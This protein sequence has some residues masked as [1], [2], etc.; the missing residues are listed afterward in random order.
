MSKFEFYELFIENIYIG[1]LILFLCI[2]VTLT[3][4]RKHIYSIFD[5][6]FFFMLLAASGYS[7]VFFLY[8]FNMIS[9]Y[10]F[11]SF[12]S[13]Q[14]AFFFGWKL[15]KPITLNQVIELDFK[16][17]A[18]ADVL[19][20][21]SFIVFL[22]SQILVYYIKGI[23]LFATSRLET[24][25]DGGGFGF[26]NR[27][28][29]VTSIVSLCICVFRLIY[30]NR[31]GFWIFFDFFVL[32][33]FVLTQVFSGSK[34]GL[35]IIIFVAYLTMLFSQKFNFIRFKEKVA[36]RYFIVIVCI[37]IPVAFIT[38][39]IQNILIYDSVDFG[40]IFSGFLMRFLNTGDIYYMAWPYDFLSHI[41]TP[42]DPILALFK[43]IL[44]A[45]R[46]FNKD[47]LPIHIGLKIFNEMY[48]NEALSGPNAR[49]N[50][51]GLF[52]FGPV[53]SIVY[54][55]ILG[56]IVGFIRNFLFFKVRNDIVGLTV[57]V[58]CAY[59]S[60]FIEQD[61]SGM[62]VMYFFSFFLI[63]PLLILISSL[64]YM[65]GARNV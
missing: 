27:L 63:Y 32:I 52:Y 11:Y 2:F 64:I 60:C 50:V 38:I 45:T 44:G 28:I 56:L 40:F 9:S 37:A 41:M 18:F 59:V 23:P 19:Y 14:I 20:V 49:H 48:S 65:H 58:F 24:F 26:F 55:F 57:F 42:S 61:F 13:T 16:Y 7:V 54:S 4:M 8:H 34:S 15:F 5:P 17:S 6:M 35:L 53:I 47:E 46:I 1:S 39:Y 33:F 36:K 12:L 62:A 29:V 51:F 22:F 31:N 25:S 30:I 21:F 43:D 3:F 10:Y